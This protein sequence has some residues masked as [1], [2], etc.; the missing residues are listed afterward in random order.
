MMELVAHLDGEPVGAFTFGNG[1]VGFDYSSTPA[2][3]DLTPVSLSMPR[4]RNHHGNRPA[5][6]FLKGLLPDNPTA[7]E[8]MARAAHTSPGSLSGLLGVYGRDVA[9]ALQLLPPGEASDDSASENPDDADLLSDK[10]FEALVDSASASY[11]GPVAVTGDAL[12]FS[13]AG[14][15]PKLALTMNSASQ[16]IRPSR[17]IATT[18]IIKPVSNNDAESN[19]SAVTDV[20]TME[21]IT[22]AAAEQLGLPVP[23]IRTWVSPTTGRSALVIP[24]YDRELSGGRVRRHHQED[25]CQAM[26]VPPEKKYQHRDQGPGVGQIARLFANQAPRQRLDLGRAFF[27]SLAF[28]LGVLGTDAHAKN[29]SILLQDRSV[30]LAPLYDS[31][32][33]A[34]HVAQVENTGSLSFPMSIAGEYKFDSISPQGL[35]KEGL[36]LGLPRSEAENILNDLFPRLPN[37]MFSAAEALGRPDLAERIRDGLGALSLSRHFTS[38]F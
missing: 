7:L 13:V 28:N 10:E 29:Y 25:L 18:H 27:R 6:A 21:T 3:Q 38:D 33:A 30:E 4:R 19:S 37:A 32:S 5:S 31:I 17:A 34:A 12:R 35:V 2:A 36:R 26:A 15:Q 22:M 14:A 11:R 16:W 20:E 23:R 24:R 1:Q 8:N 9:G